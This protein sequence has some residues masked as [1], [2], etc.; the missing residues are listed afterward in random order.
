MP[1][2]VLFRSNKAQWPPAIQRTEN[3]GVGGSIPSLPTIPLIYASS[4]TKVKIPV[5]ALPPFFFKSLRRAGAPKAIDFAPNF[6]LRRTCE[7]LGR[8][9]QAPDPRAAAVEH[10]NAR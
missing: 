8:L 9:S 4:G 5:S 10:V 7:R 6:A 1:A 3:P 2:L